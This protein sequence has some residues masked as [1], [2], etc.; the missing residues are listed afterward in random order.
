MLRLTFSDSTVREVDLADLLTG[1]LASLDDDEVFGAATV[2]RVAG[3]IAWPNGIELDPDVLR[4]DA[5]P[6]TGPAPTLLREYKLER[7][8]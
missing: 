2:D 5:V 6:A 8:S 3:T 4:G 1:V 7:S